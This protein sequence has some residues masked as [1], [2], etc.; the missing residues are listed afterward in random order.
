MARSKSQTGTK[1]K[2]K[3]KRQAATIRVGVA[4]WDYKDW[5]GIVY[6]QP[7]PRGFDP[8]PYLAGFLDCIEINT[9]FYRP[10]RPS[11]AERWAERVADTRDFRFSAKLWQRFT[12][13]RETAW[14]KKEVRDTRNGFAPLLE[15]GRLSTLLAQFPWSFKNDETNREWIEDVHAAFDAFP[16]VIEVRHASWNVPEF[17]EWLVEHGIGFVNIDQPQFSKSIKPSAVGTARTGYI[18]VHGRNY[19]DWFRKD[20]GRDAR[21]DYLYEPDQLKPWAK[22]AKQLAR[23]DDVE[24]V[25]V[26]FNN[27]YKGQAVV[28]ALQFKKLMTRRKVEAPPTLAEGFGEALSE[29]GV[30]V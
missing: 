9:T 29:A 27:H 21:Y 2:T 22:R 4:G 18:R 3:A 14:K 1:T 6:P 8:L 12:H 26:V 24:E 30:S 25:D 16:L 19:S 23:E 20:A 7:R 28:N 15:A 13:D 10:P 17:F 11:V 5:R